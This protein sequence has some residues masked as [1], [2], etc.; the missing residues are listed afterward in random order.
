MTTTNLDIE[1]FLFPLLSS[2]I[3]VGVFSCDNIPTDKIVKKSRFA[4][5]CNLSKHDEAGSHFITILCSN[6]TEIIYID[7][8]GLPPSNAHILRFLCDSQRK[9]L[10]YNISPI[11]HPLSKA[12][13]YFSMFF[14]LYFELA[15]RTKNRTFLKIFFHKGLYNMMRNDNV[16]KKLILL[17]AARIK[18]DNK[19]GEK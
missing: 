12:C 5:I 3:F 13:G 17:I 18:N 8:F 2:K 4:I 9:I 10:L 19:R 11:Q 15:I 14:V 16:C 6:K 7:S 1:Q